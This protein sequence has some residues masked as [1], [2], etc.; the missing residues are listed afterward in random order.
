MPK[1][2][3]NVICRPNSPTLLNIDSPEYKK[4]MSDAVLAHLREM[5]K[6]VHTF[7]TNLP[8]AV[9]LAPC[10]KNR[11]HRGVSRPQNEFILYRKDIQDEI[12]REYPNASFIEISKI[13][14]ARW[15]NETTEKKNV[16][17]VL[18]KAGYL[19]HRELFPDYKYQPKERNGKGKKMVEV[20]QRGKN[21]KTELDPWAKSVTMPQMFATENE[22][23]NDNASMTIDFRADDHT[24]QHSLKTK[25]QQ[26]L[27]HNNNND[28]KS[29]EMFSAFALSPLYF[30]PGV[31]SCSSDIFASSSQPPTSPM[32]FTE[33]SSMSAGTLYEDQMMDYSDGTNDG[34]DN[35]KPNSELNCAMQTDDMST[36]MNAELDNVLNH[37]MLSVGF[38]NFEPEPE[39]FVAFGFLNDMLGTG[40]FKTSNKDGNTLD[41]LTA[42]SNDDTPVVGSSLSSSSVQN[43]QTSSL[44][45]DSF[46][47]IPS[48]RLT[49]SQPSLSPASHSSYSQTSPSYPPPPFTAR[50]SDN[51]SIAG[52]PFLD[53]PSLPPPI[54][55]SPPLSASAQTVSTEGQ[56]V[57]IHQMFMPNANG[58]YFGYNNLL[59]GNE[60]CRNEQ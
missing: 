59:F 12:R 24:N 14:S 31:E 44:S 49:S 56:F 23:K 48:S 19:A 4:L 52:F 45:S 29:N 50:S 15:K 21:K 27:S 57:P 18:S 20:K 2:K 53:M 13:A 1:S 30:S 16:F 32:S 22:D 7:S 58:S 34:N 54:L 10:K 33:Q 3:S 25:A 55:P 17:T 60:T 26:S 46:I 51:S 9:L 37:P 47:E 11:G 41:D 36:R 39:Q 28:T 35:I 38:P 5:N 42:G 6:D 8:L 43:E 40:E